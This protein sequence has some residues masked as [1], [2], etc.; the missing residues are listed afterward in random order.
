MGRPQPSLPDYLS[1]FAFDEYV[2]HPRYGRTPRFTAEPAPSEIGCG[3]LFQRERALTLRE[4]L[5]LSKHGTAFGGRF[6]AK[7]IVPRTAIKASA[8]RLYPAA[9]GVRYY[10]DFDK[11]C[12]SCTRR[13]I[14]FAAEQKHWYENL[15]FHLDAQAVNCPECRKKLQSIGRIKARYEK[16]FHLK[17]RSP[18]EELELA[19]CCLSLIEQG[20]FHQRQTAHVRQIL[21]QVPEPLRTGSKYIALKE[22]L[23]ALAK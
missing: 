12:R 8:D 1:R 2:K 23:A 19:A 3:F 17:P 4:I 18:Q 9:M 15:G 22:R 10:F 7:E 13:F 5:R 16:L 14:F 20:I 21:K 6:N 11:C